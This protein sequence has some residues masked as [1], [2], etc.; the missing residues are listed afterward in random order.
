MTSSLEGLDPPRRLRKLAV[1]HSLLVQFSKLIRM[2]RS[3]PHFLFLLGAFIKDCE[4]KHEVVYDGQHNKKD[5]QDILYEPFLIS[6]PLLFS[7][8]LGKWL[9][10]LLP[11]AFR[12]LDKFSQLFFLVK[13][14]TRRRQ[15]CTV[16]LVQEVVEIANV[17][18]GLCRVIAFNL[19][20]VNAVKD[21]FGALLFE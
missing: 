13:I 18:D 9:A 3:I 4:I 12:G 14:R 10:F 17:L 19:L 15:F 20:P 2:L 6:V 5:T 11:F 8:W 21:H 7:R 1:H 16:D